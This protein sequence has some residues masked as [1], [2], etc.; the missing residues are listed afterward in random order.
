MYPPV[1]GRVGTPTCVQWLAPR[2]QGNSADEV[3]PTEGS[4]PGRGQA[5]EGVGKRTGLTAWGG[6]LGSAPVPWTCSFP[7][8][9]TEPCWGAENPFRTQADERGLTWSCGAPAGHS[10]A[11]GVS[12][13]PLAASGTGA[14]GRLGKL[15]GSRCWGTLGPA[16]L[17]LHR[18]HAASTRAGR[19]G[20][21]GSGSCGKPPTGPSGVR[22]GLLRPLVRTAASPLRQSPLSH[23]QTDQLLLPTPR[24]PPSSGTP[25]GGHRRSRPALSPGAPHAAPDQ[26]PDPKACLHSTFS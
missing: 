24:Q 17:H 25:T 3:L 19:R 8:G 5:E 4:L 12:V 6:Q 23:R 7:C 11:G 2:Q 10:D 1:L 26:A 20:L 16:V 18:E 15:T 21:Q 9:R 22:M 13:T 14:V